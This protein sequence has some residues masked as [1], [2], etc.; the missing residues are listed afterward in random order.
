MFHYAP[1]SPSLKHFLM[2]LLQ[3]PLQGAEFRHDP[4]RVLQGSNL[5]LPDRHLLLSGNEQHL[6]RQLGDTLSTPIIIFGVQQDGTQSGPAV[7]TCS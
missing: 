4:T 6:R 2:R 1:N 7:A 5:S 3:D